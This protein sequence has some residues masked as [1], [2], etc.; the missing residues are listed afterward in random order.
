MIVLL[1]LLVAI[2]GILFYAQNTF[3]KLTEAGRIMFFCGLLAFLLQT[4]EHVI[5][6][7]K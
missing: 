4:P 2:I 6:L 3:P 1:P 5:S 7:M